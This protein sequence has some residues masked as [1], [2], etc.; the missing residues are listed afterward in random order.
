M[1]QSKSD[2]GGNVI[3]ALSLTAL[4]YLI[5]AGVNYYRTG[6]WSWTPWETLLTGPESGG[7]L[8]TATT[9][10]IEGVEVWDS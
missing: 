8:E 1:K 2:V 9:I 4:A 3:L 5:W 6:A 7:L 10:P